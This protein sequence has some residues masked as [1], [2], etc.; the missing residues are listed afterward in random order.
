[1]EA[2]CQPPTS[3]TPDAESG[4]V[5]FNIIGQPNLQSNI[6]ASLITDRLQYPCVIS[7]AGQYRTLAKL[8]DNSLILIDCY[9]VGADIAANILEL[10]QGRCICIALINVQA[11]SQHEQLVEWPQLK[12]IFYSNCAHSQLMQGL[13]ELLN[14][15]LWLPRKVMESLLSRYRR[16]P[17]RSSITNK[18]TRREREILQ[19]LL[20]GATNQIIAATLYVSEHTVKSH[21]YNVFK[22]IGVSNRLQACN[23]AKQYL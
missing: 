22:K 23:W 5:R 8:S 10:L 16:T 17:E 15:G 4:T 20:E 6:L 21:L 2:H 11:M 13:E 19:Q 7:T 14:D 18:L 9:S 1:M 12:G 3:L